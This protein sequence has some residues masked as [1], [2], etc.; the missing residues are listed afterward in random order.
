[1]Y[2]FL[3]A[4]AL[5]K[6]P[7]ESWTPVDLSTLL[8]R[9]IAHSYAEAYITLSHPV[10]EE[11]QVLTLTTVEVELSG[12][13]GT[14]NE[15]LVSVGNKTLPT[16]PG[17]TELASGMAEFKDA[18]YAGYKI[19][20]FDANKHPDTELSMDQKVDLLLRRKNVDYEEMEKNVLTTVNGLFHR[21]GATSTGYVIYDGGRS[22]NHAKR[23]QVGLLNFQ[24][25]SDFEC[26]N[27]EK[28]WFTKPL[29][30]LG[31][32][33]R[34]YLKVPKSLRGKTV[35]LVIAGF[36]ITPGET[37]CKVNDN[38]LS[39]SWNRLSMIDRYYLADELLDLRD[40]VKLSTLE[41]GRRVTAEMLSDEFVMQMCTLPQSFLV[42]F[43]EPNISIESE[44][45][46]TL[47]VPGRWL[48]HRRPQ[49]LLRVDLGYCPEYTVSAEQNDQYVLQAL[50]QYQR[51][52]LTATNR[53]EGEKLQDNQY[54][55]AYA[56]RLAQGHL[57]SFGSERVKIIAA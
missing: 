19:I 27:I 36:L 20:P 33:D 22:A 51:T 8:C 54:H 21:A 38:V 40:H 17:K 31:Y 23:N 39:V 24:H 6:G 48:L 57:V 1:M 2:A 52:V 56:G 46:E 43:N 53:R 25:V 32:K 7:S 44:K 16:V 18:F 15:W 41:D 50:P 14:F 42:V 5:P 13:A 35:M 4:L 10:L 49:G 11:T 9:D 45:L 30:L 47:H 29:P 34:F 3:E 26:I 37:F 55:G 12:F 28:S